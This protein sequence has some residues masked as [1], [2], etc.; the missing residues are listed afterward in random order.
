[1][2]YDN[3]Q[4]IGGNLLVRRIP[5]AATSKGGIH[6]PDNAQEPT[7]AATVVRLGVPKED[8][9]EA[10]ETFFDINEGDRILLSL[11]GGTD[12]G[13]DLLL[14]PH[15]AVLG[16]FSET[17]RVFPVGR[18]ILVR[19]KERQAMTEGGLHIPDAAQEANCWGTAI[20]CGGECQR[21]DG[22]PYIHGKD[23]YIT[24]QQGTHYRE[25]GIDYI[26]V[27]ER[28]VK[29]TNVQNS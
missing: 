4:P 3:I 29:C 8:D 13:D 17:G 18:K 5:P 24:K 26:I 21:E 28:K 23:V 11:Y 9:D 20:R 10:R 16:V 1:M 2:K 25:D 6:I 19:L 7:Q 12:I 14:V 15:N 22:Y 27:D